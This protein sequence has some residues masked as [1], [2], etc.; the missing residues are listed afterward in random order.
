MRMIIA[1]LIVTAVMA[2]I[3]MWVNWATKNGVKKFAKE[4]K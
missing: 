3:E 1:L 2:L 4:E